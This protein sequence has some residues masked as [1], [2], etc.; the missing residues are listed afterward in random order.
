MIDWNVA[1][2]ELCLTCD[3]AGTIVWADAR[4]ER[5]LGAKAGV[6]FE[7]LGVA[8]AESKL[9][10][11]LERALEADVS[12]WEI[13][14]L[15]FAK[16]ATVTMWA[17]F[18]EGHVHLFGMV[19]PDGMGSTVRQ[20]N[21][22]LSEVVELNRELARR[23]KEVEAKNAE[24]TRA[25][26]ELDESKR[27][28]LNLHSELLEK[29]DTLRRTADVRARVV[30]NVSHEFR[31]PLHAILGLSNL[32][33]DGS[34]GTLNAEQAKQLGFIRSSAEELSQLVNDMLD[35]SKAE[36]GKAALRAQDFTAVDCFAALRGTMRPLVPADSAVELVFVP[37]PPDLSLRTDL[38]KVSQIMRNLI[39][40]ALK[41]TEQGEIRVSVERDGHQARF[42]VKDTGIGVDPVDLDRIFEEFGQVE[43][44]LQRKVKGTGLGLALSRRLADLLGGSLSARSKPGSGSTFTLLVP[45]LHPEVKEMDRLAAEPLDP[46]RAPVLV[47]EDDRKTLFVYEKYLSL[48]GFQVVPA[49]SVEDARKLLQT[50]RP[51]A[52]VLDVMLEGETTWEFLAE[53]KQ[54]E[55]TK[56]LP[57]LVVTVTNREQKARALGADEF[58]LKPVDKDRLIRKLRTISAP[59]SPAKVLIIDDDERARYLIQKL[60]HDTPYTV[61]EAPTGPEGL[62]QALSERPSIILLDF[63][64]EDMTAFD[65][66]DQLKADPRTR[67][68]PVIVVTSHVLDTD[69]RERLA[70][71]TEAILSKEALSRELAI[72]RIRDALSKARGG[73]DA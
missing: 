47:V 42:V 11:L 24:L 49:R 33:L 4:A 73:S 63:L 69:S 40:N 5:I 10:Q 37:P 66:L 65:V 12:D 9:R 32:L 64:L 22:A 23:K 8:G 70:A 3:K 51:A 55:A 29:A 60:L 20:L 71:Q 41:F 30:A 45:L 54:T 68:I 13:P 1:S 14:L 2:R 21:D 50:L 35:L 59:A 17:R 46:T 7:S 72:Q 15:A 19:V 56:D 28:V 43:G 61:T 58:W 31:T 26:V 34:D 57:V 16:P 6:S 53:L 36:A 18:V 27:G 67:G 62:R 48:A 39:S 44:P 25:Y 52:I 38:G